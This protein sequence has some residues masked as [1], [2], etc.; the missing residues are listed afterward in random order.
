MSRSP[1]IVLLIQDSSCNWRCS[2]SVPACCFLFAALDL[3]F[4]ILDGVFFAPPLRPQPFM[5]LAWVKHMMIALMRLLW[6]LTVP[7]SLS[8]SLQYSATGYTFFDLSKFL[9]EVLLRPSVFPLGYVEKKAKRIPK[10]SLFLEINRSILRLLF[11]C[12][13]RSE[14]SS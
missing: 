7:G 5:M 13:S 2:S 8:K 1:I 3:C 4:G 9:F 14:S 11:N 10:C 12:V 6:S